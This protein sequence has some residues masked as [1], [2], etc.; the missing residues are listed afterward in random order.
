MLKSSLLSFVCFMALGV[1]SQNINDNLLIYYSFDGN[2]LDQSGNGFHGTVNATLTQ[3][4][5]GNPNSAYSFN[6]VNQYIDLPNVQALKPPLPIS[7]SAW[8]K[9]NSLPT[10]GNVMFTNNFA[11]DNHSGVWMQVASTGELAICYGSAIGGTSWN[12]IRVKKGTTILQPGIW[13]H[14]VGVARGET[15][16]DLYINCENDGGYYQGT[17]TFPLAYTADPGSIGRK[18]NAGI[19]P[20]YFDGVLDDYRYWNRSLTA[21]EALLLCEETIPEPE[22]EPI[23][24]EPTGFAIPNVF[25]PNKDQNNDVWTT[26]FLNQDE[27]IEILDRWGHLIC[28]LTQDSPEWDGTFEGKDCTDGVYFYKG[29]MRE[30][31][32]H[33]FLHLIR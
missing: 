26:N 22:P 1:F 33:G 23:V 20:Y 12:N 11:Q 17:T 24:G 18:D 13:Y 10:T 25:T 31:L 9:F 32:I 21:Q 29:I 5:F 2:A 14:V 28:T 6:G 27:Y 16:M 19:P 7:Y 8:V 4:R 15:D 3:D 30:E